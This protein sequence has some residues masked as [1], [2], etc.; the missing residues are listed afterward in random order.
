MSPA[1]PLARP[2]SLTKRVPFHGRLQALRRKAMGWIVQRMFP[3]QG[4]IVGAGTLPRHGIQRIL[5]CRPNHRLGNTVLMTPLMQELERHYPGSEVDVL[6]TGQAARSI[7]GGFAT[8][9]ELLLLD[10][11]AL[12]HPLKTLSVLSRL[13]SRRYDLVIDA[14]AGSSSGRIAAATA[15]ARYQLRI[16]DFEDGMPVHF[17]GRAIHALRRALGDETVTAL[18]RPDL[19]LSDSERR[20][21]VDTLRR[22]LQGHDDTLPILAIFPNAT[23]AKRLDEAWWRS[24]LDTLLGETGP[25]R[26]VELVAAD[27]VSRVGNAY[28]TYFT[29][30]P[31]KLAAVIDA[32]GMYISADCG[33][34]HLAAATSATTIGLFGATDPQRYAPYG[35]D[36]IGFTCDDGCPVRTARRV[37]AHLSSRKQA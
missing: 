16:G 25:R 3:S 9:G 21:G 14:A 26:I 28:S 1:I 36:N 10:R 2:E 11:R 17:A 6:A 20:H 19:R 18:P 7:Y 4:N 33:V 27:G 29:S 24:F 8:L 13:R 30:D 5:V 23:G 15:R 32:A 34:M 22:V 37:A 31:R 12:R 35:G